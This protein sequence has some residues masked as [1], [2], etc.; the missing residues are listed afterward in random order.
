MIK[1]PNFLL[2]VVD[3]ERYPP[4]YE[5]PEIRAWRTTNLPAHER[6][7]ANSMELHRHYIGSAACC[8]S[9]TTMFTGHYPSLHGVS[10]TNGIAKDAFDSDMFW[11]PPHT[12]PTMGNYFREAGYQTYYKGKWHISYEDI[13][14]PG[15]HNDMPS[16]DPATGV[17]D[18]TREQLYLSAD[19][20]DAFG[21]SSWIGPEPH[22]RNPHNSASSSATGMSGRD[23]TYGAETVKL[24]EAL[25]HHRSSDS[26]AKPWLIVAS[27]VNPHDITLYGLLSASL[28]NMFRFQV[29]P[30]PE[31]PAP[32]TIHESLDTKPMCQASYRDTYPLALQPIV[33]EPFYRKLYYQLQKN[34]DQQIS[35]VLDALSRSSFNDDTIVIFTSD[36]GDL[37][38]AH[39]HLRQKMYCAYEEVLHVP[40]LIHN[41][42]LFPHRQNF[43]ELTS[44]VDLLPTMLGLASIDIPSL[45]N[46]LKSSFSEV[47]PFVGRDLTP[48]L[49]HRDTS[50]GTTYTKEPIYFMTDDEITRGQHQFN[51]LGQSYKAVIQPNHIETVIADLPGPQ[52]RPHQTWKFTRYFDNKQFW[53]DPGVRDVTIQLFGDLCTDSNPSTSH[54][55]CKTVPVPEEY[56]LYNLTEDPLETCNLAHPAWSN[57][58]TVYV[59]SYMERLLVDQ[60]KHKR[61]RQEPFNQT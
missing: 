61:L 13:L 47:R 39:G 14:V 44:H 29:D 52:G 48:I 33:N 21:F 27:F 19:P 6:L 24:I 17:P 30:M 58:Q 12:V 43:S 28:P 57:S 20:L 35:K 37:L 25:D 54:V 18:S 9:R 50:G 41:K 55:T 16:Y 11:L 59:Q 40:F 38:G 49:L 31:V 32:P 3:E 8:P 1:M 60:R 34:A 5:S 46:Q 45:Q 56:E 4:V 42:R 10:Q 53:S 2:V 36:H 51:P 23:V 22:G 15:T 26:D 7:R